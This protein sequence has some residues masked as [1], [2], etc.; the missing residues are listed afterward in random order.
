MTPQR[1]RFEPHDVV[2]SPFLCTQ[3]IHVEVDGPP[4]TAMNG[5]NGAPSMR[6]L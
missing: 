4:V 1:M 5:I 2:A 3:E 6:A